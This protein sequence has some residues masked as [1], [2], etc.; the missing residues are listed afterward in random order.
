M[1]SRILLVVVGSWLLFP[2]LSSGT[3]WPWQWNKTD[4][5]G[6]RKGKWRSFYDHKP[7]QL[8]YKGRY[9]KGR[10][11]G[12]WKTYSDNGML[13]R[14]EIYDPKNKRIRT[15][16]YHPNGKVSHE[17]MAFLFEEKSLLMYK[18]HGDWNYYD[19]TGTWRGWK[20]FNRG[21]ALSAEP[22]LTKKPAT[23]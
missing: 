11:H 20:S 7:A 14:L 2:Q 16:F 22:I 8:M 15:T 1:K 18:W 10:E 5:D 21:K 6:N 23:E 13:E 12:T 4:K 3:D 19:S 9:R 17:G